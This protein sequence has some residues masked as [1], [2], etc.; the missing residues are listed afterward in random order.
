MAIEE[1][2]ARLLRVPAR[3]RR[4]EFLVILLG[5]P[6]A[7]AGLAWYFHVRGVEAGASQIRAGYF[8]LTMLYLFPAFRVGSYYIER[9]AVRIAGLWV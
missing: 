3:I 2:A 4:A 7:L 5:W 6:F 9:S 1:E 8:T